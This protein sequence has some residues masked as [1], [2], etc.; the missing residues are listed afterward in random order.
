MRRNVVEAMLDTQTRENILGAK[1]AL[2]QG[3]T[4]PFLVEGAD[5]GEKLINLLGALNVLDWLKQG[6][7][8]D[9]AFRYYNAQIR[10]AVW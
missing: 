8:F 2:V 3:K 6:A 5:E 1:E 10:E 7:D 9:A 4:L